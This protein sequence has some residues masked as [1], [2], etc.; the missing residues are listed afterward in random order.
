MTRGTIRTLLRRQIRDTDSV[1]WTDNNELDD[2]INI[3]YSYVQKEIRKSFPEA[4]IFWD[5]I[6][7]TA[8]ES[9]YPLPQTFGLIQ[10]GMKANASDTSYA[11]LPG[12]KR[13][14]DIGPKNVWSGGVIIAQ[15]SDLSQTYYTIRG[16]FIGIFPAPPTAITSGIQI[17]HN[18]IMALSADTEVPRIKTPLHMAIL[19]WSKLIL[20][21]DTDETA[22]ET[23][24]R[25]NEIVTDIPFWY[26][27]QLGEPEQLQVGGI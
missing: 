19:W 16:Q 24:A 8:A 15:P 27:Q 5:Y 10:V 26:D 18:P 21:G 4:H 13:Y 17:L 9:W 20:L 22:S 25:L 12:P 11:T 23:R 7:T 3:A 14:R 2:V 6:N 1:Q